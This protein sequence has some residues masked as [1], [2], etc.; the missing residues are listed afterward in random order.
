MRPQGDKNYCL[1]L[2]YALESVEKLSYNVVG[3]TISTMLV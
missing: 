3:L 1:Y 2:C